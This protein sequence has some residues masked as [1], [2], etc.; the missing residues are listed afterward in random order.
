MDHDILI[1]G[2]RTNN[3]KNISVGIKKNAINLIIGPSGSG[4]S[5]LA[6][7]TIAQIGQHE[8]LAMFSDDIAEPQYS[9]VSYSNMV[10]A[11]PI[12]QSNYNHNLRSTIGTYFGLSRDIALVYAA[13]LGVP[14]SV[15]TLNKEENACTVCHGLGVTSELDM[16]RVI[17][18]KTLLKD[19]PIRC[20]NKYKDFY[21]QILSKFC[22][23]S[24]IDDSKTFLELTDSEKDL[25]L[26]GKSEKKYSIKY[27]KRGAISSKTTY[28]YGPFSNHPMMSGFTPSKQF[29]SNHEC[30]C[31]H[32]KKYSPGHDQYKIEG[33]SIGDFMICPF[34]ELLPIIETV[35]KKNTNLQ[36]NFALDRIRR[37]VSKA[38]ELQ[39]GYLCFNRSIPTLSGGEL[40][41]LK[42]I[43]VFNA[44]LTDLLVVLDEP[45][46]GLSGQEK[47]AVY[48]NV[49]DIS[50]KHTLLIVDHSDKFI[51]DAER[52]FA[53]G[54][55]SGI[56]GGSLI[57][58]KAYLA[59]EMVRREFPVFHSTEDIQ[60]NI[61]NDIY[62]YKGVKLSIPGNALSLIT[63]RSGIGKS[64][65]L[66]EYCSQV[67]DSYLYVNQK[68]IQGNSESSVATLLGIWTGI[69]ESFASHSKK[70][71]HY[72]SNHSGDKGA[73]PSC[74]GSGY[75][76]YKHDDR[77]V[78]RL[79]CE[80]CKG[81]GY[82]KELKKYHVNGKNVFDVWDMT[83][84]EG[85]EYF[86]SINKKVYSVL[87]NATSVML[88]HLRIG[89]PTSSLSGGENVRIGILFA[90][91][92]KAS[93]IGIDEPF[94]GLSP[95]EI[96]C[97]AKYLDQLRQKGKTIVVADHVDGAEVYFSKVIKLKTQNGMITE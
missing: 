90:S 27:K 57:D 26:R 84:D 52:I 62:Q 47:E 80:D 39:L 34:E 1:E 53:L 38:I 20:W 19:C 31:C 95:S 6:Y 76:E 66:R 44:Q 55:G 73:C 77:T 68:P 24:G 91:K 83:I 89:Q 61:E 67:F 40:Q 14:D 59:T 28:Y 54:P 29:Y 88:G 25:I 8:F 81:T 87:K 56:N 11:I 13:L 33:V 41:R 82:N 63:G 16:F 5:S 35:Y 10:A 64:T 97:V 48:Q 4:K 86:E 42:M 32:G 43:Q 37:F 18:F 71:V 79:R 3:L 69:A 65:L 93:I 23:D 9:V 74:G 75:L 7:D 12:K 46:A 85:V 15:F 30:K 94:R 2:I 36:L 49:I 50:K 60:I 72:F 70:D 96:Y 58:Y 22:C 21:K 45:L 17:S 51:H 78:V 92:S